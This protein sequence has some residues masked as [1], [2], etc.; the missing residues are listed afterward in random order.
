MG[1]RFYVLSKHVQLDFSY[2]TQQSAQI[3]I[4]IPHHCVSFQSNF[5]WSS[6]KTYLGSMDMD[7]TSV[8]RFC[9][10]SLVA[11]LLFR[12]INM[13]VLGC[14]WGDRFSR[15]LPRA[16]ANLQQKKS[17]VGWKVRSKG[18]SKEGKGKINWRKLERKEYLG[19]QN[20]HINKW[21]KDIIAANR[22]DIFACE[23]LLINKTLLI[24]YFAYLAPH[25]R[26][27]CVLCDSAGG[28]KSK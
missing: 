10:V 21:K 3:T 17:P 7:Q 4:Y 24:I 28:P 11:Y 6:C 19:H 8:L 14:L 26:L 25:S 16:T 18:R 13:I 5:I 23:I 12:Y 27:G 20:I 1:A 2:K 15:S 9:V 22:N